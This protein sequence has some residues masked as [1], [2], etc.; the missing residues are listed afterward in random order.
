MDPDVNHLPFITRKM[1][2]YEHGT[3][4]DLEVAVIAS[5]VDSVNIIGSTREGIFKFTVSHTGGGTEESTILSIPDIPT[6]VTAFTTSTALE[7]GEFWAQIFLR[8]NGERIFKLASG[9]ITRQSGLNW[10]LVQNDFEF[11]GG[12]KIRRV[13]G[14]NPAAGAEC[15]DAVTDNQH[16]ILKGY[17]VTLVTDATAANRRVHLTFQAN[18]S[19]VTTEVFGLVDQTASQTIKY[20]FVPYGH[21]LDEL[22]NSVI[23]VPLPPDMHLLSAAT[24]GTSTT[25][26]Q[27]GDNFGSPSILIE[28]FLEL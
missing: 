16:W 2:S 3:S 27:A 9:Y 23:Q 18:G 21:V 7:R 28:S 20:C 17:I 15:A 8:A 19:T 25:N 1:L 13:T 22:D 14:A 10:P 6:F 5:V 24:I 4:F 11:A 12:G 26:L